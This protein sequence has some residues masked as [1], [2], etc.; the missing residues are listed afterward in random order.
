MIELNGKVLLFM[1]ETQIFGN[2]KDIIT[3]TSLKNIY[4]LE[5]DISYIEDRLATIFYSKNKSHKLIF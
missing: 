4:D 5:T 2:V 3:Q 1:S